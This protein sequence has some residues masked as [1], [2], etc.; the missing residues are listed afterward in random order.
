MALEGKRVKIVPMN[1]SPTSLI[2]WRRILST[3]RI[4]QSI[5]F[6]YT[7]HQ[8]S[9]HELPGVCSFSASISRR[10]AVKRARI[11]CWCVSD[12]KVSQLDHNFIF[13]MNDGLSLLHISLT[14]KEDKLK[15]RTF[16]LGDLF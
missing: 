3:F 6:L 13:S 15:Q 12:C 8:S 5:A 4:S 10:T 7:S 1:V 14:L 9:R 16:L 11:E 2:S